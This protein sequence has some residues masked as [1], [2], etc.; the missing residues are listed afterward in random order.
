MEDQLTKGPNAP[1]E[2]SRPSGTSSEQ[3]MV[4]MSTELLLRVD[5]YMASLRT[6]NPGVSVSRADAM[7]NLVELGLEVGMNDRREEIRRLLAS[8]AYTKYIDREMA[9]EH[10]A[11]LSAGVSPSDLAILNGYLVRAKEL[12]P[13]NES[14]QGLEPVYPE[15]W[16]G[17]YR[18]LLQALMDFLGWGL[19]S[20]QTVPTP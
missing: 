14:I 17:Q 10:G 18:A 13:Q 15:G 5:A 19:G 4:R 12:C 8:L 11:P 1:H 7:R 16:Y 9:V 3:V 6:R 2:T 20:S